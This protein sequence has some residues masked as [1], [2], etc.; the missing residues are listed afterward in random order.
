MNKCKQCKKK[1]EPKHR[2]TEQVCSISCAIEYAKTDKGQKL[3]EKI[4]KEI[5]KQKKEEIKTLSDWKKDLQLLINKIARLID[6][7]QPCIATGS[8]NGKMNGGHRIAVGANETIRFN[9]HNIHIQSEHSN[10]FKGGDNWRYSEGIKKVYGKEYLE[11]LDSLNQTPP[12]KLTINEIKESIKICRMIIKEL[13]L[14]PTIS[15]PEQRIE[16]R[17]K[18]NLQIG[19]Y[20]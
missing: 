5:T 20:E 11:Y 3:Q 4:S 7:G 2:T 8:F 10:T 9:L 1:F 13:E 18:Y 14:N 17:T 19:I 15:T 16:L 12:I 6:Y